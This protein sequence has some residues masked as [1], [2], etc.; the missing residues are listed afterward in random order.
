MFRPHS[1]KM[2]DYDLLVRWAKFLRRHDVYVE[3]GRTQDKAQ[4]LIDIL[5]RESHRGMDDTPKTVRPADTILD[6]TRP[7]PASLSI[8][9]PSS[10]LP[11]RDAPIALAINNAA[12]GK[13]RNHVHPDRVA[14]INKH[15][16]S[17]SLP[18]N[19]PHHDP[20]TERARDEGHDNATHAPPLTRDEY[21]GTDDRR[22]DDDDANEGSRTHFGHPNGLR[23]EDPTAATNENGSSRQHGLGISGLMKAYHGK[24]MFTGHWEEDLDGCLNVF[25]TLS[26]MCEITPKQKH[27]ALPVMLKGDALNYF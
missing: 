22:G 9:P 24:P 13:L 14:N 20:R 8:D 21:A 16:A 18:S 1:I 11:V 10:T 12:G 7:S 2:W 17:S 5:Y 27:R 3:T 19:P 25:N 26:A 6:L 4:K 15:D 23:P